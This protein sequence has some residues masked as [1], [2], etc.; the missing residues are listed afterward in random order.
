[1]VAWKGHTATW[2]AMIGQIRVVSH[3]LQSLLGAIELTVLYVIVYGVYVI[4]CGVE[5]FDV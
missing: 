4:V 5:Y 1:M 3:H 2:D